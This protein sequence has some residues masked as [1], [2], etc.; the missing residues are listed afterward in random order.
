MG[1]AKDVREVG[2]DTFWRLAPGNTV[3]LKMLLISRF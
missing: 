2:G 3:R 1:A